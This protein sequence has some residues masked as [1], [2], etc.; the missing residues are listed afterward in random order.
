MFL[1]LSLSLFQAAAVARP[2]VCSTTLEAPS[3]AI[4]AADVTPSPV[5][6]TRCGP[7]QST[8]A[9]MEERFYG[10]TAPY[11][12]GVDL[13]HQV[14]DLLGIAV[15]GPQGNRYMGF[16]FPDQT[17]IWD[18]TAVENTYTMLLEDQSDPIPWRT[19]DIPN[20]FSGSLV[21][22]VS[23]SGFGEYQEEEAFP[24]VRALW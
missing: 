22:D 21:D 10:W 6:V 8:S 7:V 20:G 5:E 18:G 11:A 23:S 16:G 12:S 17:I 13:L 4:S 1:L 14:T 15:A 9:F 19:V 2:V 3:T 24:P